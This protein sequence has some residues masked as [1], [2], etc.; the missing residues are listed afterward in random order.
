MPTEKELVRRLV[1]DLFEMELEN[2]ILHRILAAIRR[3]N[4]E[5]PVL[6]T[7]AVAR[8]S[9][10][11]R[12]SVEDRYKPLLQAMED[13]ELSDLLDKLPPSKYLH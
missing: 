9:Q 7:L 5:I 11:L 13:V 8:G 12:Q 4:P 2:T 6:E 10:E 1:Q 3:T